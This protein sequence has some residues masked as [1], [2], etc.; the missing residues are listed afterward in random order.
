MASESDEQLVTKLY[1]SAY[2]DG[3]AH[4]LEIMNELYEAKYKAWSE[5]PQSQALVDDL[6]RLNYVIQILAANR[7]S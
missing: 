1:K 4:A 5:Q 2:Q 3:Y 7:P 6:V